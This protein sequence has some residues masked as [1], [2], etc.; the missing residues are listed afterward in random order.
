MLVRLQSRAR[1]WWRK[2]GRPARHRR[3]AAWPRH[4]PLGCVATTRHQPCPHHKVAEFQ[5][6]HGAPREC[7]ERETRARRS[8]RT[9]A[10]AGACWSG[11][12]PDAQK[13]RRP[14]YLSGWDDSCAM[15]VSRSCVH[16]AGC[17]EGVHSATCRVRP[18]SWAPRPACRSCGAVPAWP[19]R[20][21][22][23]DSRSPPSAFLAPIPATPCNIKPTSVCFSVEFHGAGALGSCGGWPEPAGVWRP[24]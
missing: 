6:Q 16:W 13:R 4:P 24:P 1:A 18:C 19:A 15:A 14:A 21:R 11:A 17:Q 20:R 2:N 12:V 23:H 7:P 9:S 22:R 3:V 5:L 8:R 10:G